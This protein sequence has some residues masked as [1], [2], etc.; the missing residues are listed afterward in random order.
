MANC[1]IEVFKTQLTPQRNALVD[2]LDS[3]LNTCI[4]SYVN[5]EFQFQKI[6]LDMD[7]K[8]TMSD[9]IFQPQ[10]IGNYVRLTQLGKTYYLFI[11]GYDWISKNCI[12]LSCSIDTI[13]TFRNDVTWDD[14][15]NVIREHKDRFER[16]NNEVELDFV[17]SEYF[18]NL[19]PEFKEYQFAETKL[20]GQRVDDISV[21]LDVITGYGSAYVGSFDFNSTTGEIT[22]RVNFQV[23][24]VGG[25]HDPSFSFILHFYANV[26]GFGR[27]IDKVPEGINPALYGNKLG[28]IKDNNDNDS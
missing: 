15:T 21:S 2:E 5:D 16:I 23:D 8:L 26:L 22:A 6:S 27:K 14:K 3:Y 12:E 19:G 1:K 17:K 28:D 9:D 11:N 4:C 24:E 7:F 10:S 25:Q 18:R 13:N 20:I